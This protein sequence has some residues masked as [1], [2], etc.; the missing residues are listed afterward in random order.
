MCVCSLVV[1]FGEGVCGGGVYN[2]GLSIPHTETDINPSVLIQS[3]SM[4]SGIL[5]SKTP[6]YTPHTHTHIPSLSLF[7]W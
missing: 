3:F 7:L 6:T 1:G 5:A 4:P 2:R